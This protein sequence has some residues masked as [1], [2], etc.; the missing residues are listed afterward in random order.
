MY[1]QNIV[2]L[3]K[4]L[5]LH[6]IKMTMI[7]QISCSLSVYLMHSSFPIE[8]KEYWIKLYFWPVINI[9]PITFHYLTAASLNMYVNF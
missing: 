3:E 6:I 5:S 9:F 2:T 7:I 8:I 1:A 4:I